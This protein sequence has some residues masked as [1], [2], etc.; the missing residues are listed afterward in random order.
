MK[1]LTKNQRIWIAGV[2]VSISFVL[3]RLV[4]YTPITIIT[5]VCLYLCCRCPIFRNAFQAKYKI[6]GIDALVT[7]AVTGALFIGEYWE[8]K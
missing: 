1:K 7:I 5:M 8:A 2:L 4:G 3:H 6:V